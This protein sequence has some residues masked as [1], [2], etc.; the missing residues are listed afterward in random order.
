ME[1]KNP[2]VKEKTRKIKRRKIHQLFFD[3]YLQKGTKQ[4]LEV[5][6]SLQLSPG[7]KRMIPS[8]HPVLRQ[9]HNSI[10]RTFQNHSYF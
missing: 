8:A 9:R 3:D 1:Q 10:T 5:K 2:G 4:E 7:S 6:H